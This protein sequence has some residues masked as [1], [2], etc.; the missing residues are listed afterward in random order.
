MGLVV[1]SLVILFRVCYTES[2][3]D[4]GG[5][6]KHQSWVMPDWLS[7]KHRRYVSAACLQG[8]CKSMQ[9]GTMPYQQLNELNMAP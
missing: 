4:F 7:L 1:G 2:L 3:S 9:G 5:K 8:D 6:A